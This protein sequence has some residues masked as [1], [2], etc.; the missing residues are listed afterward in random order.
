[1]PLLRAR[2]RGGLATL[3]FHNRRDA[4]LLL[5]LEPWAEE[6]PVPPGSR[7]GLE[8]SGLSD[9]GEGA[10]FDVTDELLAFYAPGGTRVRVLVNGVE[11]DSA[12]RQLTS[13]PA[14]RFGTRGTIELMFGNCPQARPGG[15]SFDTCAEDQLATPM[16]DGDLSLEPMAE[17]HRASLK[18]ACAE[19]P[20]IWSICATSYDPEHFDAA[21]DLIRSRSSWRCFSI[22][23]GGRL[24]GMS[25]YIGIDP[26]RGVLEVGNTYYIPEMR[27]TGLNERVK[28]LM[29]DRAFACGIRRVEFRVDSRNARSQAAMAKLGAVREGVIRAERIT[30][31]GHVRDT[32]LFSILAGEWRDR[33]RAA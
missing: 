19:D 22:V 8:L 11:V 32:V 30:W 10:D 18:A 24:V 2:R 7:I 25:C 13:P 33:N 6:V 29:L 26:A 28:R 4:E 5:W 21:F 23:L 31:T 16:S 15:A 27:G 3:T 17:A 12:S 14:R 9:D 20:E 1:M